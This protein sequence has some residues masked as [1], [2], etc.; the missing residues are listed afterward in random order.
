MSVRMIQPACMVGTPHDAGLQRTTPPRRFV[1]L[2]GVGD[3]PGFGTKKGG[4][5]YFCWGIG[6]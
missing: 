2:H 6:L 4:N 3:N 1:A 5:I